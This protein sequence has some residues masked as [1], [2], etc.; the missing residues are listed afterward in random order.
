MLAPGTVGRPVVVR[1]HGA[2]SQEAQSAV[3]LTVWLV[4]R[5]HVDLLRLASA[6]C[7]A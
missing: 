2:A 7:R 3:F 1:R 5:R 4:M 6:I